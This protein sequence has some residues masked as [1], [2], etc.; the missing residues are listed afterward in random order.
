MRAVS[1]VSVLV[2]AGAFWVGAAAPR[3]QEE[4]PDVPAG[5]RLLYSQDFEDE[6]AI[7][8]FEFTDPTK[9][10]LSE[11]EGN[12]ALEF[13]GTGDYKPEVRSPN[14]IGL[15]SDRV[16]GDFILEADLLQTGREYGHRDMCLFFGFTDPAKFYYVHMA[17]KADANA[18]NMFIVNDAP[19]TNFA[20]KTTSGIQWGEEQWH[21]VRLERKAAEGT[22]RVFFDDLEEPIMVGEERTFK[23][24]YL[25]FGSFDDSGMVDNVRIWGPSV[26]SKPSGFFEKK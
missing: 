26:E 12:H 3:A 11:E 2:I 5:Y 19:R 22:I 20:E 15:L 17:S 25:G 7:G 10:R 18:H 16:F 9:W 1:L 21:K 13:T 8:D 23:R 4:A 6:D 14:I 24:G